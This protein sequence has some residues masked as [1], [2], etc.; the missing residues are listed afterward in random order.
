MVS[1][2]PK[3]YVSQFFY[4]SHSPADAVEVQGDESLLGFSQILSSRSRT[5]LQGYTSKEKLAW[6]HYICKCPE[7]DQQMGQWMDNEWVN[8]WDRADSERQSADI[9]QNQGAP[10]LREGSVR[11]AK[12]GELWLHAAWSRTQGEF[13]KAHSPCVRELWKGSVGKG[14]S[15]VYSQ[16]YFCF[17]VNLTKAG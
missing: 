7:T 2:S 4:F 14:I 3:K 1:H 15:L 6:C 5:H 17:A 8:E 13:R 16:C 11:S 12:E 9:C 10:P